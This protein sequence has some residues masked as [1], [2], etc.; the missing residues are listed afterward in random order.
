MQKH[1]KDCKHSLMDLRW[2]E[3]KCKYYERYVR[4]P[5]KDA[6]NCIHHRP[7]T[8]KNNNKRK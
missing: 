6:E 8:T 7:K 1:C 4:D 2:G 5:A 3:Y